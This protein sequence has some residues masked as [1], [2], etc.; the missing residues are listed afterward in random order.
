MSV[1]LAL[2]AVAYDAAT[3]NASAASCLELVEPAA[4]LLA[5]VPC[6]PLRSPHGPGYT[7]R[8]V[9]SDPAKNT[10]LSQLSVTLMRRASL[11]FA[12][13]AVAVAVALL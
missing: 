7:M 8:V 2:K 11:Y 13:G 4:E 5:I 1:S 12:V 6:L 9:S 10:Y 3:R